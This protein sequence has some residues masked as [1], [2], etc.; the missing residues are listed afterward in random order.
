MG[1]YFLYNGGSR[2]I[3]PASFT[4]PSNQQILT[5]SS[6]YTVTVSAPSD[7]AVEFWVDGVKLDDMVSAGA[8]VFTYSWT[9]GSIDYSVSIKAVGNVTGD[10]ETLTV[11][12]AEANKVTQTMTSWNKSAG[13]TVTGGQPFWDGTNTAYLVENSTTKTG[14]TNTYIYTTWTADTEANSAFEIWLAPREVGV[15]APNLTAGG[16]S[17]GLVDGVIGQSFGNKQITT[18]VET[19][20]DSANNRT[21]YRVQTQRIDQSS[22]PNNIFLYP[23]NA[24]GDTT[25]DA[26]IGDG[27]YVAL[28]RTVNGQLPLTEE[29]KFAVY[30]ASE[31]GGVQIWR[32][33]HRWASTSAVYA[34]NY[35]DV[36]VIVPTGWTS[37]GSYKALIAL[38]ALPRTMEAAGAAEGQIEAIVIAADTQNTENCV[39]IIPDFT[40]YTGQWYGCKTDGTYNLSDYVGLLM[41]YFG[42]QHLAC[43]DNR[44]AWALYGY[45]KSAP[46]AYSLAYIH[47]TKFGY[48]CGVDGNWETV[49]LKWAT[50]ANGYQAVVAYTTEAQALLYDFYTL[51]ASDASNFTDKTRLVLRGYETFQDD[52]TVMSARLD[53]YGVGYSFNSQDVGAHSFGMGTEFEDGVAEMSALGWS[54]A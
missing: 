15:F 6:A 25:Y 40:G 43:A 11:T 29:Q 23:R 13:I 34:N 1:F 44:E 52:L 18:I 5:V 4:A 39:V 12:I 53:A 49:P 10:S 2:E 46:G 24:L 37:S 27:F 19:K 7:S 47:P 8:G 31:S 42:K 9:P 20:Y 30:K 14:S 50:E 45:S 41:T 35:F 54:A 48:A 28:P 22:A 17:I 16:G 32:A 51:I 3:T 36:R 21:W 33:Q 38:G 26:A